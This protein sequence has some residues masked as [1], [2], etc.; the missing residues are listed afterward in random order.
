MKTIDCDALAGIIS[1]Y[2]DGELIGEDRDAFEAHLRQCARCRAAVDEEEALLRLMRSAGPLHEAPGAL[3]QAVVKAI[4]AQRLGLAPWLAAVAAALVLAIGGGIFW[5]DWPRPR[6]LAVGGGASSEF[7]SLGV[8]THLRHVR[9]QLPLEVRSEEPQVIA[10]W[11]D[12]RVPFHLALPDYPVGL[13]ERKPYTLIGGRL[14]SFHGDYAAYVV[15]RM[16]ERS[17]S[18]L[19][20]STATVR[21]EGGVRVASG[22]LTFHLESVAG[23][24]VITWADRGLTYALVSDLRE[25]GAQSCLVCHGTEQERRK[26]DGLRRP[27]TS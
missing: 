21:P 10:R 15:Y 19:V 9:G 27:P 2:V 26:L 16:E 8:D 25:D 6:P 17:I 12:G 13:G 20:T 3:R 1:A 18:L 11:F 14:V 23:L 7:A 4:G 5:R 24:K 22:A